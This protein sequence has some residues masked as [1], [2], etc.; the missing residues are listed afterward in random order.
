MLVLCSRKHERER[1]RERERKRERNI[2]RVRISYSNFSIVARAT[3]RYALLKEA[4]LHVLR[5]PALSRHWCDRSAPMVLV[6]SGGTLPCASTHARTCSWVQHPSSSSRV[7][8]P[9]GVRRRS[10]LRRRS[11]QTLRLPSVVP[12]RLAWGAPAPQHR[13]VQRV[14]PAP[15]VRETCSPR[16]RWQFP[17]KFCIPFFAAEEGQ[18]G[19]TAC[20]SA[21]RSVDRVVFEE[22][23]T[24]QWQPA[25]CHRLETR[26]M[27][28]RPISPAPR[29]APALWW[30][31]PPGP[32]RCR[33]PPRLCPSNLP[34]SLPSS[35]PTS[36]PTVAK[37]SAAS[38][39]AL[40]LANGY[41]IATLE[42][43]GELESTAAG[44]GSE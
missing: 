18:P 17:N 42:G 41:P 30:S 7:S 35:L 10:R 14:I 26:S 22:G 40:A 23:A 11:A 38:Q 39:L 24:S 43:N 31:P 37:K 16:W 2:R 28:R 29:R 5:P 3:F 15:T 25:S 34:A 27:G 21:V 20:Q 32:L 4:D 9:L 8:L 44:S 6:I 13:A 19:G 1:E 33:A 36:L 12:S